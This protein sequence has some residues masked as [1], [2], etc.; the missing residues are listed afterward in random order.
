MADLPWNSETV[1]SI[2]IEKAMEILESDHHGLEKAKERIL[3]FSG[4]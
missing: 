3:E 1:D 2:D 4:C